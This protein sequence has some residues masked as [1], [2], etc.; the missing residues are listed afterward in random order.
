MKPFSLKMQKTTL[1]NT[2][3][4]MNIDEVQ[5][6]E[7]PMRNVKFQNINVFIKLINYI[8]L[9]IVNS[10]QTCVMLYVSNLG[11]INVTLTLKLYLNLY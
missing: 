3:D 2:C 6:T 1:F 4:Y 10:N 5:K 8:L 11:D 7:C 9:P